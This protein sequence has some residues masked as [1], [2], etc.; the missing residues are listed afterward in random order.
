[1]SDPTAPTEITRANH[2]DVRVLWAD[3]HE[4][5]YRAADLR[6]AC[7]CATCAQSAAVPRGQ[8]RLLP[9]GIQTVHPLRI[10]LVGQY[11]MRVYWSD[12][13][14]EGIYGF[15]RLRAVCPCC[16]VRQSA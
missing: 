5:V 11:G 8:I 1:M 15:G 13:H 3:G 10:E 9:S 16:A 4:S 14:S 6:L 7:P 2:H 12:G